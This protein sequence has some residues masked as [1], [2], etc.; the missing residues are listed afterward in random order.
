[1]GDFKDKRDG[2]MGAESKVIMKTGRQ[3]RGETNLMEFSEIELEL[4]EDRP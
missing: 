4:Q 3:E 2:E 1:M